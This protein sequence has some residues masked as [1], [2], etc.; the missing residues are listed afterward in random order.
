M[1]RVYGLPF[2]GK[3]V[4][5]SQCS[6][7]SIAAL[8][9]ELQ[10]AQNSARTVAWEGE[11]AARLKTETKAKK[12]AKLAILYILGTLLTPKSHPHIDLGYAEILE[13]IGTIGEYNWCKHVLDYMRTGLKSEGEKGARTPLADYHFLIV[14][15]M[16]TSYTSNCWDRPILTYF[17]NKH[18]IGS[19]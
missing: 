13:D 19:A 16:R 18:H 10:I 6:P 1:N 4:N 5:I 2:G 14:S 9:A 7:A 17:V 3:D 12:W 8:K 15:N 11:V